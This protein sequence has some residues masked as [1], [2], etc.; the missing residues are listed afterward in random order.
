MGDSTGVQRRSEG[1]ENGMK[2]KG[3]EKDKR[4][5]ENRTLR[6][7][8]LDPDQSRHQHPVYPPS[9]PLEL[10]SPPFS[11]S[12]VGDVRDR[13]TQS[14]KHHHTSHRQAP[15]RTPAEFHSRGQYD[16]A[17]IEEVTIP[18]T[19]ERVHTRWEQT[20]SR[21]V[22]RSGHW[23]ARAAQDIPAGQYRGGKVGGG[24]VG[25]VPVGMGER[26][27]RYE[28]VHGWYEGY[29]LGVVWGASRGGIDKNVASPKERGIRMREERAG[30]RVPVTLDDW[31]EELP[32]S[33]CTTNRSSAEARSL[34]ICGDAT[35]KKG[36]NKDRRAATKLQRDAFSVHRRTPTSL[37]SANP[38]EPDSGINIAAEEAASREGWSKG[39]DTEHFSRDCVTGD[40]CENRSQFKVLRFDEYRGRRSTQ[41]DGGVD[42]NEGWNLGGARG[43][44]SEGRHSSLKTPQCETAGGQ[45]G[46][47]MSTSMKAKAKGGGSSHPYEERWGKFERPVRGGE[48]RGGYRLGVGGRLGEAGRRS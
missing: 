5:K 32:R 23:E 48:G 27:W 31:V 20:R 3:R 4:R 30:R 41:S 29:T 1:V 40:V 2:L 9:P 35:H 19:P 33:P 25:E 46:V 47:E 34:G 17:R 45:C 21:A 36:E 24:G 8:H 42:E 12:D 22:E 15:V 38:G 16:R 26:R 7:R 11:L 10:S 6:E 37:E 28:E 18:T 13:T 44:R 43:L 39:G 14:S